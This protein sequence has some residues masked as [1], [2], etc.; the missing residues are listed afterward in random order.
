[1]VGFAYDNCYTM[2]YI[3]VLEY[4][5]VKWRTFVSRN[6][7]KKYIDFL[8]MVCRISLG[9]KYVDWNFFHYRNVF[10][11]MDCYMD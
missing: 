5:G 4:T 10:G 8:K 9:S 11:S 2:L 3:I 7:L 1:M 6:E